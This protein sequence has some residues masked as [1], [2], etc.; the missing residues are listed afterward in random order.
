MYIIPC[1]HTHCQE[2]RL[3]NSVPI[4]VKNRQM[5]RIKIIIFWLTNRKIQLDY[6]NSCKIL[7][8]QTSAQTRAG[9]AGKGAPA[10]VGRGVTFIYCPL[11]QSTTR[12]ALQAAQQ[13]PKP[14]SGFGRGRINEALSGTS[15]AP[16]SKTADCKSLLR[17]AIARSIIAPADARVFW[18]E[19]RRCPS[20]RIA[21]GSGTRQRFH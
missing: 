14:H 21:A 5:A 16:P 11:L 15:A 6:T 12:C 1:P 3:R 18:R 8:R 7:L 9:S 10:R 19:D 4:F 20:A 2:I 17:F 13:P